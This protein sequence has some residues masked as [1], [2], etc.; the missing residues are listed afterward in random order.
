MAEIMTGAT[1]ATILIDEKLG[2][3]SD[4]SECLFHLGQDCTTSDSLTIQNV[5]EALQILHNLDQDG[6]L[7]HFL[8]DLFDELNQ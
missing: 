7:S 4:W 5:L 1:S 2:E 6:K 8:G 3:I